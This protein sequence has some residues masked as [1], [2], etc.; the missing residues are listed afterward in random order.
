MEEGV[1]SRNKTLAKNLDFNRKFQIKGQATKI[2]KILSDKRK[3]KQ[4]AEDADLRNEYAF[5]YD[6]TSTILH[7]TSYSVL[8]NAEV[9]KPEFLTF[10][11][12]SNT[13][14]R[15]IFENLF[16]FCGVPYDMAII[17]MES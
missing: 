16:K 13:F 4:K 5:V 10:R 1:Q 7:C 9:E 8:T 15:G 11:S 14:M 3:W 12:L 6:Y 2:P 17:R